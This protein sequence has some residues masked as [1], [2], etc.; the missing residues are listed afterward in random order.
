MPNRAEIQ[1]AIKR[2]DKSRR[3]SCRR[4]PFCAPSGRCFNLTIR[5]G[6][7]GDWVY[8][9]LPGNIQC[10]RRW[11]RP[12]DPRTP[13]QRLN[14]SRFGSAS[15]K[16][17]TVLT[18]PERQ[19]C[20][21]AGSKLQSRP[22]LGQSGP[23]TGQ[24]Y[25]VKSEYTQPVHA[26]VRPAEIPSKVPQKIKVTKPTWGQHLG[27]TGVLPCQQRRKSH[28]TARELKL[29][30]IMITP[31]RLGSRVRPAR[32]PTTR[33]CAAREW[34]PGDRSGGGNWCRRRS[35]P[36][37]RAGPGLFGPMVRPL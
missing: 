29:V 27:T 37:R 13:T 22:R 11:V 17:S 36:S 2:L 25:L 23:L 15:R 24:Q 14:R 6:R 19:A 31:Q 7:C 10:R 1:R 35:P 20:I 33:P 5:N 8:Y 32:R 3:N 16:Y 26:N 12:C 18:D 21:V 4:C 9:L 30:A 28:L 34:V